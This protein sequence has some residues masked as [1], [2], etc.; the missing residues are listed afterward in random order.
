M[1]STLGYLYCLTVADICATNDSL[2]NDWKGTLLKELFFATQRITSGLEN[3]PDM[4]L[5]IREN[6]RKPC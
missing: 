3:P 4:R 2:W 1:K 6:Q 5:R